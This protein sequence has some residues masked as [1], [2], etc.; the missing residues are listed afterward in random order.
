MVGT[1]ID[2]I[3]TVDARGINCPGPV[4]D[5]VA[6][7]RSASPNEVVVLM[8]DDERS[9]RVVPEWVDETDHELLAVDADSDEYD[10]Y[11]EVG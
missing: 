7:I 10:F 11:V 2:P 8:S 4:M 1:D 6:R 9:R 3:D 5:L